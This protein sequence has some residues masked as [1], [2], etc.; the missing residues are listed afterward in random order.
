MKRSKFVN[1]MV[2]L[3]DKT[4]GTPLSDKITIYWNYDNLTISLYH[5][6]Y[7]FAGTYTLENLYKRFNNLNTKLKVKECRICIEYANYVISDMEMFI[8]EKTNPIIFKSPFEKDCHCKGNYECEDNEPY[9]DIDDVD[10]EYEDEYEEFLEESEEALEDI[11]EPVFDV[12][13]GPYCE[14]CDCGEKCGMCKETCREMREARENTCD[15]LEDELPFPDVEKMDASKVDE[16]VNPPKAT[17]P[18]CGSSESRK[19]GKKRGKQ[20]YIC[21]SCGRYFS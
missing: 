9:D 2:N 11:K 3:V 17:C 4:L 1:K 14:E 21:K 6:T 8:R 5:D 19:N 16:L 10:Y 20:Q 18:A 15:D 7:G 12:N 13:N